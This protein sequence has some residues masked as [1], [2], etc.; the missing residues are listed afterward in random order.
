M[1]RVQRYIVEVIG[2]ILAVIW[3]SPFY[4]MIV[5]SF[6][7][8]REIFID[9][10]RLPEIFTFD[11]YAEA[12]QQLDFLKTFFNSLL[13]TI[14]SVGIIIIFSSMGFLEERGK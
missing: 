14:V 8:K 10:L 2:I 13:I 12:F 7:T 4:L 9:T 3:I 11:N 5:N 1:R 6:K